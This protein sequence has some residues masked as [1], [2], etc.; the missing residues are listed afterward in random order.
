VGEA[1][2]D[3]QGA[4]GEGDARPEAGEEVRAQPAGCVQDTVAG[5]A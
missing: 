5:A 1:G 2:R 4:V 3:N